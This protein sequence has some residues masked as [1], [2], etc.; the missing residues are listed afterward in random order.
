M[1]FLLPLFLREAPRK[2]TDR[3]VVSSLSTVNIVTDG[4]VVRS[5]YR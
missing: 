4:G 2:P 1:Q 5:R 3:V